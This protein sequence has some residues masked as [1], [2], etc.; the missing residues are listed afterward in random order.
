MLRYRLAFGLFAAG[1]LLS[2]VASAWAFSQQIVLPDGGNYSFGDPDKQST[3]SN[4]NGS[5]QGARPFGSNGLSVQFGVQQDPLTTFGRGN[6]YNN[7]APDPYYQTL[8][9]GN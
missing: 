4:N 3:T 8:R 9:P 1:F 6:G 2:T 7:S 5:S